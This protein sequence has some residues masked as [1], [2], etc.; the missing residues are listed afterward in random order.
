MKGLRDDPAF[1][2]IL[3][4]H[5]DALARFA[6]SL[7]RSSEDAKDLVAE[8]ILKAYESWSSVREPAAARTFFFRIAHRLYI[9]QN[10]RRKLFSPFIADV[11]HASNDPLPDRLTDAQL[12]RDALQRMPA[13]Q[14]ECLVLVD[15][16]GWSLEDVVEVHGG[17]IGGL[18]AKLFR[19]RQELKRRLTSGSDHG[20]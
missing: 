11:E 4:E 18:K 16:L 10:I 12:V 17:T 20:S 14:R 7:T 6:R 5:H 19:A 2:K 3:E 9:R 15:V 13:S 1:L 8:T